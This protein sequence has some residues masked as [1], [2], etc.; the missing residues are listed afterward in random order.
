MR[1]DWSARSGLHS[2]GIPRKRSMTAEP[3]TII[4]YCTI[5]ANHNEPLAAAHAHIHVATHIELVK[6]GGRCTLNWPSSG[7]IRDYT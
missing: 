3:T 6:D 4:S 1:E 7:R 5:V 2:S